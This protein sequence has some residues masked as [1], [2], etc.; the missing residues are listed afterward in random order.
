MSKNIRTVLCEP[1]KCARIADIDSSLEGLQAAVG[2]G[3]IEAVWPFE[4]QVCIV[5]NEEGK[6]NGMS[7]NRAIKR[8]GEIVD[9]IAG[10]FFIC[11]CDTDHFT[12]LTEEQQQ[13]FLKLFHYPEQFVSVNGEI[14]SIPYNPNRYRD[15]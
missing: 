4:E 9:I 15:R 8:D 7:L 3:L 12:D 2:G 5:C 13:T 14:F 10:P 6:I 11:G 1:G